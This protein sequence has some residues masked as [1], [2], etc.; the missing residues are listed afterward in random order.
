MISDNGTQY[1]SEEFKE[2][3]KT[4][5]FKHL[6]SSPKYPKGNGVAERAIQTLKQI[7]EKYEDPYLGLLS[8][9]N[10][11]LSF[12]ISPAELLMN[13]RL[14]TT[15]PDLLNQ[16]M[17][18][19]KDHVEFKK[20][21][22]EKKLKEKQYGDNKLSKTKRRLAL[23]EDVYIRDIDRMGTV[24]QVDDNNER[25]YTIK[26]KDNTIRLNRIDLVPV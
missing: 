11:P 20:K 25:T 5:K 2:F 12:G 1:S 8:Y 7:M 14:N 4:Y 24:I 19:E 9:R 10:T 21:V 26:L 18:L 3:S 6:T 15:L 13:R 23:D 17:M 22:M 16:N